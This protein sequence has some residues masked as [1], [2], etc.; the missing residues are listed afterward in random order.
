[1]VVL[2]TA[3]PLEP[4]WPATGGQVDVHGIGKRHALPQQEL[5]LSIGA[6]KG[7]A[8]ANTTVGKYHTMAGNLTRTRIAVQRIAHIARAPRTTGCLLYT[9]DAADDAISV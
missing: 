9:S 4:C 6:A 1:M 7:K 5:T 3:K 2:A 8:L